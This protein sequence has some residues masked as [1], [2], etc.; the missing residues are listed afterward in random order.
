MSE[1][2]DLLRKVF[3]SLKEADIKSRIAGE[4]QSTTLSALSS[5]TDQKGKSKGK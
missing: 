5:A 3:E 2:T 1:A 4:R